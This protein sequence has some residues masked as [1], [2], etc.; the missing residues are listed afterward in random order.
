MTRKKILVVDDSNTAVMLERMILS[1]RDYDIVVA[2]DGQ[3]AVEKAVREQPDLIL[4]DVVMPR[5]DGFGACARLRQQD[6]TK[7]IPIILVTTRGEARN[8]ETGFQN[9]CSD[10]VTKPINGLELL[11]KVKSF[12]GE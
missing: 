7:T 10:Y 12:L 11:S 9:G 6:L 4:M 2:R 3:E 5:L 8:I 1:Q